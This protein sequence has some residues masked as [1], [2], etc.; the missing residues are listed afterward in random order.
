[1][2][3]QIEQIDRNLKHATALY[4]HK[5][6]VELEK[7][8][9]VQKQEGINRAHVEE[10][11]IWKKKLELKQAQ[12]EPPETVQMA[13]KVMRMPKLVIKKFDGTPQD[14]LRFWGQFESRIDESGAPEDTKFSYLKEFVNLKVPNLIDGFPFTPEGYQKAEYLLTKRYGK[15]SE[16]LG[17]YARNILELPTVRRRTIKKIHECYEVLLFNIDLESL[18]TMKSLSQLD[19]AVR[20]TF[21]KLD[22]IKSELAMIDENWCE[23]TFVEFLEALKKWTI[24]NP[25]SNEPKSKS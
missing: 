19:T 4:E 5:R 8:K 23:W 3:E 14:W 11:G 16:V 15:A 22:V 17:T 2:A 10:F 6:V 13:S 25:I 20:F 9:M 21:D 18:Q 24:N 12:M 7:E 1:M